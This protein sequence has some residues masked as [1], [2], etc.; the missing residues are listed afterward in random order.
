MEVIDLCDDDDNEVREI[1]S[2]AATSNG[3]H[4]NRSNKKTAASD[5]ME[6]DRKPDIATL[7]EQQRSQQQE[8][9]NRDTLRARR[10]KSM[11]QPMETEDTIEFLDANDTV[12]NTISVSS[13]S[14]V[15]TG[16]VTNLWEFNRTPTLS[17]RSDSTNLDTNPNI[18]LMKRVAFLRVSIQFT[19]RELG[20]KPVNFG[21]NS[22][23]ASLVKQYNDN[24]R[25]SEN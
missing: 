5:K 1:Q 3:S 25:L 19:L 13:K 24:K 9:Q 7:L 11:H 20:M 16:D 8:K 10:R 15:Q 22:V 4:L 14:K 6:I 18:E 2:A 17:Q 23:L 21:Q 12:V